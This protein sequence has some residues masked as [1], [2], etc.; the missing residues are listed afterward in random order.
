M[1]RRSGSGSAVMLAGVGVQSGLMSIL[2]IRTCHLCA[3]RKIEEGYSTPTVSSW[4]VSSISFLLSSA[5]IP[6]LWP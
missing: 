5:R 6:I 1:Y 3:K 2:L 4:I